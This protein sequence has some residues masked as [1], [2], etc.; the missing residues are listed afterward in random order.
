M[1]EHPIVPIE[2]PKGRVMPKHRA[3]GNRLVLN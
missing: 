1:T 2:L 3:T